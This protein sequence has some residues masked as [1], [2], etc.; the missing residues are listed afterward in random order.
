MLPTPR[1]RS[2]LIIIASLFI[3]RSLFRLSTDDASARTFLSTISPSQKYAYCT[4]LSPSP[5][6]A[7]AASNTL[8]NEDHYFLGVR[9][10]AY[11][12]LH[13]P[14]TRTNHSIPLI[15][16]V[17]RDVPQA[18]RDRLQKDGATVLEISP[19]L[20]EWIKPGRE[21]WKRVLDKLHV[22]ELVQF[23][24][25]LLLDS[26]IVIV[27]PLDA[28]F[29]DSSAEVQQ[30]LDDTNKIHQDESP[31]PSSYLLAAAGDTDRDHGL[32][33]G[34]VLLQPSRE[35]YQHYLS[36]AAIEGRFNGSWPEQDLWNYAHRLDGNMP[37]KQIHRQWVTN[38]PWY[39]DYENGSVSL[40]EKYWGCGRDKDLRDILL[41]TRFEMEG[42]FEGRDELS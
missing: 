31:Q 41:R 10:L 42:F 17:T 36:I 11:R 6:V 9:M 2:I 25:I 40:H 30:S 21:R 35:M 5:S 38:S 7:G 22:F 1:L 3:I 24:K 8:R 16:L 39:S 20:F 28:I 29:E 18:H 33:A 15:V 23:D 26:D 32:N 37:W 27:K 13:D 4:F 19:I 14:S 34:F 12:L